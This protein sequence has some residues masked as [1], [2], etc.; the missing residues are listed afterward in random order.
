MVLE[1]SK[2]FSLHIISLALGGCI[3]APPV[4]YGLTED[5]GGHIAYILGEMAALAAHPKVEKAEI[6]TRLFDDDSLGADYA[7]SRE[8]LPCGPAITRIDSGDRRYLAKEALA[9]D[10]AGFTEAFIAELQSRDRLPDLIHAHFADAAD[11]ACEVRRRLGIPYIYTAHSL[12]IDKLRSMQHGAA[13]GLQERIAEETR[14]VCHADAIVASS[15]DECER[16]LLQYDGCEPTR[17]HRLRPG[18]LA[19]SAKPD[20]APAERLIAPFL[21]EPDKPVILA[22]ARPVEKKNL[23]ALVEAYG[24]SEAL[25]RA[26]NLVILAGLRSG[27]SSGEREQRGVIAGLVDLIDRHDLYG[28]VA[29]P[30]R[31]TQEDVRSLYALAGASGGVFVNPALTEPYGL[32]LIEAAAHGL[33]VV[34]TRNG[35]PSDILDELEHGALVDPTDIEAIGSATLNLLTDRE[36][37]LRAAR[38][39]RENCRDMSWDVYADGFVQLAGDVLQRRRSSPASCPAEE[40]LVC[41]IDNTLTG[42]AASAQRFRRYVE[43][44]RDLSFCVATGRSLVE[45]RR[46][47]R[48]WRL[49]QP[50]IFITSV[51]SEVYRQGD[52][53]LELDQDF[54]SSIGANWHPE[55]IDALLATVRGLTPQSAVEQRRWK[56]SYFADDPAVAGRVRRLLAASGIEAKVIYSHQRL[57]DVLPARAGKGAAMLHVARQTEIA[58]HRIVAVGDSGNDFDML[59]ECANAV[60]VGNYDSD[61]D[62]L[63]SA[64]NVYVARRS[65]AGGVLEGHL[66]HSRRRRSI[67]MQAEKAA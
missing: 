44:R 8:V 64:P 16:Q 19:A 49:P 26:A 43:R 1:S 13:A 24:R 38:N 47:L 35:G 28:K 56:R 63:V 32:T 22:I 58:P 41:D 20:F 45:A 57:L 65:H 39:G 18:T 51:G 11:V 53:G 54:A 55:E 46:I 12:G 2:A 52:S 23:N 3:K 33:P 27:L 7:R 21:R 5:T 40:L 10:R 6:V 61:L 62:R 34:A 31:H 50:D 48:E 25:Q 4:R 42:C 36:A 29:Y 30:P 14:A 67:S 15:R 37:W 17:V 59:Q 60:L 9:A 66:I